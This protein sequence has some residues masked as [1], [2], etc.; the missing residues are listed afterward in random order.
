MELSAE[1]KETLE[2]AAID[3]LAR[4]E[5]LIEKVGSENLMANFGIMI[6]R[7]RDN[8]WGILHVNKGFYAESNSLLGAFEGIMLQIGLNEQFVNEDSLIY[9]TDKAKY[10]TEKYQIEGEGE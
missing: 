7:T 10:M 9:V 4:M 8:R 2:R 1:N 3:G 5:K 6:Y